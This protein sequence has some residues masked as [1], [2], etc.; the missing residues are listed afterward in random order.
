MAGADCGRDKLVSKKRNHVQ[1][2]GVRELRRIVSE[3]QKAFA[4]DSQPKDPWLYVAAAHALDLYDVASD[5]AQGINLD[6]SGETQDGVALAVMISSG[7]LAQQGK[8]P[9]EVQQAS[10]K[11]LAAYTMFQVYND[12]SKMGYE[13]KFECDQSSY[14]LSARY[15]EG[16][17]LHFDFL[18]NAM[19]ATRRLMISAPGQPF[20]T[21]GTL[22]PFY[23]RLYVEFMRPLFETAG[24][25]PE[26]GAKGE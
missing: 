24:I 4:Q 3:S 21:G 22:Q 18:E 17:W 13:V 5:A 11:Q 12:L 2:Y 15:G 8:T 14:A 9:L 10:A 19:S 20:L 7:M 16:E 26:G 6:F 23:R 1:K 25:L